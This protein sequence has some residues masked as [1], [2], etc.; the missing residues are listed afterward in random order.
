[1]NKVI[2]RFPPSPT[3]AFHVG[4]ART[5]LFNYL[6]AKKNG[7]EMILRFEDTDKE[8]SE[9]KFEKDILEGLE[10]LG[11]KFSNDKSFRQSERTDIYKKYLKQLIENGAAFEAEENKDGT[12]KLIRFK[13][14]KKEVVFEDLVRGEVKFDTTELEDFI[15]AKNIDEPL[16]HLAV[17]ADDIEMEI[18]HV[19]RGEDHISNTP[20]QILILE[21]LQAERPIYAHI[22]LILGKDRSKLSKRNNP[23]SVS[24]YKKRVTSDAFVNYLALLG[25]NPGD[26]EE[27]F[28]MEKLIEKFDLDKVQKGGA[29]FDEDKLRWISRQH[30]E[31]LSGEDFLKIL[32]PIL[33]ETPAGGVLETYRDR[34]YTFE[35]AKELKH[36][37]DS[38]VENEPTYASGDLIWK[39]SDRQQTNIHLQKLV[40]ILEGLTDFNSKS[41]KDAVWSYAETEGKGS[42]LW[43]MRYALTGLV[44]SPDPFTMAELLGRDET[45]NRLNKAHQ[46]LSE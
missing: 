16:Y 7:G 1:M 25:W 13:N 15:I 6:F 35:D 28:S 3:G 42:V 14:P 41:V 33:K 38:I 10:W 4:S 17:V 36:E 39:D 46:S 8:R 29:I 40:G 12:G 45:L 19:I 27:V 34:V 23:T 20:R 24:D 2:T 44:K 22:P 30:F 5:A 11:I 43:P 18:S 32:R 9:E 31:K 26:N 37:L 21:A